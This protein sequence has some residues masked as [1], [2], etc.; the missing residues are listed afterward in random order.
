MPDPIPLSVFGCQN[1]DDPLRAA[2]GQSKWAA[3]SAGV[4]RQI[5]I[6]DQLACQRDGAACKAG[7]EDDGIV[8]SCA[9]DRIAQ[10]SGTGIRIG[11]NGK[12]GGECGRLDPGKN[13]T[14]LP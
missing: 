10:G 9:D 8:G 1:P 12:G 7:I 11:R 3:K 4:D 13:Q 5:L 2:T 14:G 6:D